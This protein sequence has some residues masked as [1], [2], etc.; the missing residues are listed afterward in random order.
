M[1]NLIGVFPRDGKN[2]AR[3]LELKDYNS[4][5]P[6]L[7]RKLQSKEMTGYFLPEEKPDL[8][9]RFGLGVK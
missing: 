9:R 6:E 1:T 7:N 4:A 2:V 8:A 5:V 3:L